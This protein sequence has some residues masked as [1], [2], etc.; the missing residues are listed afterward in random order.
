[1][2]ISRDSQVPDYPASDWE[3]GLRSPGLGER[4]G[5]NALIPEFTLATSAFIG[6]ER[7]ALSRSRP[8][9]LW[10]SPVR[11]FAVKA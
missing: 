10:K 9:V 2:A 8:V 11:Q 3:R 4:I 7:G 1:M 6:T 5:D